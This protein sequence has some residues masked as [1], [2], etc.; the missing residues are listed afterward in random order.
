VPAGVM[1]LLAN[2][3]AAK[4]PAL[5]VVVQSAPVTPIQ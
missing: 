2:S 3:V 5:V 1:V 4:V